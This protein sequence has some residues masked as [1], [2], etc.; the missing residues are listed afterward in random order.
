M[1]LKPITCMHQSHKACSLGSSSAWS[2][3]LETLSLGV[4]ILVVLVIMAAA[5]QDASESSGS[6]PPDKVDAFSILAMISGGKLRCV[7]ACMISGRLNI[8]AAIGVSSGVF[9][10]VQ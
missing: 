3:S 7:A 5:A 4:A 6:A 2:C 9:V 10:V 8:D 1:L